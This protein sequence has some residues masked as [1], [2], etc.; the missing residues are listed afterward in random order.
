M[1]KTELHP[2]NEKNYCLYPQLHPFN[3]KIIV[4]IPNFILSMKKKYCLYPQ[5]HPLNEKNYC[6]YPHF[7]SQYYFNMVGTIM[8]YGRA[9][10]T[11]EHMNH[12]G[13][14]IIP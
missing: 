9:R 6:L 2:F 5:L 13:L 3:E 12:I 14:N 11:W 1:K 7:C 10:C 8:Y 4:S